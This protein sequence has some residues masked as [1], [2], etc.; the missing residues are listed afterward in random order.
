MSSYAALRKSL[1]VAILGLIVVSVVEFAA[2]T[3][4]AEVTIP[5]GTVLRVRLDTA[6]ESDGP[7]TEDAIVGELAGAIV[8]G[9]RT[10][11]PEGSH[12]LGVVTESRVA[13]RARGAAQI[14]VRF[15][16]LELSGS[17]RYDIE[18]RSAVREALVLRRGSILSV[19]LTRPLVIRSA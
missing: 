17:H 4:D 16:S 5:S 3:Q 19:R 7:R 12:V 9:G 11:L 10:I 15:T 2:T 18:T 6:L 1:I 13:G 14:A 8:V